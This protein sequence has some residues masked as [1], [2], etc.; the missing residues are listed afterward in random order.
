MCCKNTRINLLQNCHTQFHQKI[1]SRRMFSCNYRSN[2]HFFLRI[3][4]QKSYSV[5][6]P[7]KMTAVLIIYFLKRFWGQKIES[8]DIWLQCRSKIPFFLFVAKGQKSWLFEEGV[9]GKRNWKKRLKTVFS[10]F[11][12]KYIFKEKRISFFDKN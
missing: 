3:G 1:I 5:A 8:N 10:H 7:A 2:F 6:S 9:G 11:K 4:V 12:R